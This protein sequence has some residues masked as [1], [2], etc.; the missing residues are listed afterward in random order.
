MRRCSSLFAEEPFGP[1]LAKS[2]S[3]SLFTTAGKYF[4]S[5]A[6]LKMAAKET[7]INVSQGLLDQPLP[8]SPDAGV[9]EPRPAP[10][11]EVQVQSSLDHTLLRA[12]AWTG[13][14]KWTTQLVT[15]AASIITARILAPSD[16][17][18][19]GMATM[20]IGLVTLVSE[21][22]IG[23]SIITLRDLT[24]RHIAQ[25]NSICLMLGCGSPMAPPPCCATGCWWCW[26][27]TATT[28]TAGTRCSPRW[29]RRSKKPPTNWACCPKCC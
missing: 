9:A 16:Y 18:L 26:Q 23:Q 21:F 17:G 8:L 28:F 14:A 15:W 6:T 20:F 1:P 22:G 7:A 4:S 13:G 2:T 29:F 12:V 5:A 10:A 25:I 27:S 11:A 24:R 19:Y 3:S